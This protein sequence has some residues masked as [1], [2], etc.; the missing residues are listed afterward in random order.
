MNSDYHPKEFYTD[1]WNTLMSGNTW[2][3]EIYNKRKDGSCYWEEATMAPVFDSKGEMINFVAIKNDVTQR[4]NIENAISEQNAQL[5]DLIDTKNRFIS[6]L[7]HDLKNPFHTMMGLSEL[8]KSTIKPSN[9]DALELANALN[10]TATNTYQ[11]LDNMLQWAHSQKNS[12]TPRLKRANLLELAAE[13]STLLYENAHAKDI[14]IKLHIDEGVEVFVDTDM[15]KTILRNLIANAIKFSFQRSTVSVIG[16][17]LNGI[18]EISVADTGVGMS[19]EVI[20]SL[21]KLGTTTSSEGTMGEK[22]TGFGLMICKELIEK[23]KGTIKVESQLNVG[24]TFT[25]TL[26]KSTTTF[27]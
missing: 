5:H 13:C 21:F 9:D 3:G 8:L 25:I 24:T 6:I 20:E 18:T 7:A 17:Q 22:G 26:P 12:V 10:S 14:S 11:L 27:N 2:K 1:M 4:K 16:N 15:I 23:H 19:A